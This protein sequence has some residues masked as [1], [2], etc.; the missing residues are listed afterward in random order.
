[1]C[2]EFFWVRVKILGWGVLQEQHQKYISI[3]GVLSGVQFYLTA[4]AVVV[5]FYITAVEAAV[6]APAVH[7]TDPKKFSTQKF[8]SRPKFFVT[9][10]TFFPE[11]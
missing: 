4:A 6:V 1:L 5:Q 10:P 7:I 11:P 9:T 8:V 2:G 3:A